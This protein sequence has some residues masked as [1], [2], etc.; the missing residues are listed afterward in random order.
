MKK[1][2]RDPYVKIFILGFFTA[3]CL[4]L[5]YI[6][7]D[8]GFFLYAG[9]FNSQQIPFYMYA[10][11]MVS[12]GS[13]NWSWATDLGS[14]FVNSY[15]FYLLGSPFFWLSSILPYKLSPYF[16]TFWLMLK[17]A[18]A[19][20][21]AFCFLR[22]YAK[23][24]NFAF[25][26]AILYA[27]SGFSVYNIFFNHFL[28]SVA[29]FPFLLWSLDEFVLEKKR[30]IFPLFIALNLLNNYFFFIGQV[31]F[32]AIYFVA[33]VI[34]KEYKI[35][36]KDFFLLA[37]ESVTGC[38]MGILLFI[39]S[40][41]NLLQ[42][43][44][45]TQSAQGF[46]L[47]LYSNVQ[48][49]FAILLSAFFPPESPYS[50]NLFTEGTIKW[51][52][53]SA[54]VALGG[55]FGYIVFLK[56]KKSS[57]FTKIFT[58]C[59]IFALVPILNSSFY[60][61]NRSYYARWYYMPLL[62]LV[63]MNMQSF[64]FDKC[65]LYYGLKI[66]AILTSVFVVFAL[67]PRT[68][69]DGKFIL[70]LQSDTVPF[71]LYLLVSLFS[72][73]LLFV[74]VSNFKDNKIYSQKL[75]MSSLCI[76]LLFG[77]IHICL[78]KL[79]QFVADQ[80]YKGQNYDVIND[81]D[82]KEEN[83]NFRMDAYQCYNNLGLFLDMPVL[84]SFNSVVTPSIMDFYPAMGTK[85]DVS[86]KP[87]FSD[88]ALRSLLSVKYVIMPA[89]EVVN[90]TNDGFMADY[91]KYSDIPPY[92][93]F[94][95]KYFVPMGF[96]YDYYTTEDIAEQ[97]LST[98]RSKIL[99]R[100]LVMEEEYLY[101]YEPNLEKL[102][103]DDL[104]DYTLSSFEKNVE[105]R[106]SSA[107]YEFQRTPD[108]FTSKIKMDKSNF[109]FYSVPYDKG[110][111]AYVNGKKSEIIRVNYGLSAVY[112]PA[113]DNTIEFVY[114]TRGLNLGIAI[115]LGGIFIYATYLVIMKKKRIY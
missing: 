109:V 45:T 23:D 1:T 108:G 27:F 38:L 90:F 36:V 105:E 64:A 33:K 21:G 89:H 65:K 99:M 88:F 68:N 104:Y 35:N 113:G 75:L 96:T 11:K 86:S 78:V 51:T 81:F 31:V 62:I 87:E 37:F 14:S 9:D 84:H 17:F 58:A 92:E 22:R 16:M 85:R 43:P 71:W 24:D 102:S 60:A 94:S 101:K 42:N 4:L 57:A 59:I 76:I 48:Q 18:V 82:L 3:F 46:G 77:N 61:F 44:R 91:E 49:Y 19:A 67:T 103:E 115:S 110:F 114:R 52:S 95:N 112:A 10:N 98:N 72:L 50:P 53:M 111:T 106:K 107:C 83:T 47:W 40:L 5:P 97:T 7:V 66:T 15:S 63:A 39:P 41:I 69:E 12:S 25:V 34:T 6:I 30:G 20:L 13:M 54:F 100:A 55:L 8:K 70:G 80:R 28:E 32:L 2:L 79:P 73:Y 29:F 26:G 56:Y 74:V 93:I